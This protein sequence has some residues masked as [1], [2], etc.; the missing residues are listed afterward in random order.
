MSERLDDLAGVARELL[1]DDGWLVGGAVRDHLLGRRVEDWDVVVAG[2]PGAAARAYARR[3]GGSPFPLSERHGAA[4]D[5]ALSAD[6]LPR[7]RRQ[8]LQPAHA[9]TSRSPRSGRC[10][11][12]QAIS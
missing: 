6:Q 10:R 9:A 3:T 7:L 8:R 2:D 5:P 1:G 11:R 4:D 12:P